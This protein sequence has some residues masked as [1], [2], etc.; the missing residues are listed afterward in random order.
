MNLPK[1]FP[2]LSASLLL[3]SCATGKMHGEYYPYKATSM[4]VEQAYD[5]CKLEADMRLHDTGWLPTTAVVQSEEI[6]HN[7]M[8]WHG[9]KH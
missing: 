9:Y 7:C 2:L 4:N 5:I 8:G 3:A 1:H 6:M